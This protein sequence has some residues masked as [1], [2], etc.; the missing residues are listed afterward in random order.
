[1]APGIHPRLQPPYFNTPDMF[2][3]GICQ[4][5]YGVN[6]IIPNVF[7]TRPMFSLIFNH[8]AVNVTVNGEQQR[9]PANTLCIWNTAPLV[10]YGMPQT[11]WRLSWLQFF[12]SPFE[13]ARAQLPVELNNP[14][15]FTDDRIVTRYFQ[16]IYEEYCDYAVPDR[17]IAQNALRGLMLE[18]YR[19]S[20]NRMGVRNVIPP[21]FQHL[22]NHV[23]ENFRQHLTLESLAIKIHL[24]PAYLSRK[25]KEYFGLAP[26]DYVV[27]LRL[28]E[29]AY[30]LQSTTQSVQDI[31]TLVGYDSLFHFSRIFKRH[32]GLS[33]RDYRNRLRLSKS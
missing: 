24:A 10:H 4:L 5:R 1:M 3:L 32:Y 22:K 7:S 33:P 2:G 29:A 20:E 11:N 19:H 30:Y 17:E 12:P 14:A 15:T 26:I 8:D 6:Q 28:E 18:M 31:A 27:R 25:F 23:E 9:F 16:I 13:K 21:E